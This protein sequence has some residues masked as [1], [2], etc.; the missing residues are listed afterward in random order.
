[1][2]VLLLYTTVYCG[3]IIIMCCIAIIIIMYTD[4]LCRMIYV[5]VLMHKLRMVSTTFAA[6]V[7]Q[8]GLESVVRLT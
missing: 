5:E 3:Y 8:A 6:T 7:H 2:A 1:M 4:V